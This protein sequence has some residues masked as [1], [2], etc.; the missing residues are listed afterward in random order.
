V[1]TTA[2]TVLVSSAFWCALGFV[3]AGSL[4]ERL[5]GTAEYAPLL[6][7]ALAT[8]LI[9]SV[10]T[11]FLSYL[12]LAEKPRAFV[13]VTVI[14]TLVGTSLTLL[15]LIVLGRGLRGL[16]EAG[17]I[18]QIF[19]LIVALFIVAPEL[20]FGVSFR[21]I[22]ALVRIGF[23]SIFGLFAFFVIDY[24]DRT[25][26]QQ[27]VGLDEVGIYAL[28]YAFGMAIML[29]VDAFSSAWP[30]YFVSYIDRRAEAEVVF[31]QVL[32]YYLI[33]CGA[34]ALCF[35]AFARPVVTLMAAPP[36]HAAYTVVGLVAVAYFIR[37]CYLI[38]LPGIAF[39]KKL[40]F[41]SAVEWFAALLTIALNLMLI[42]VLR[43][44]G[45]ALATSLAYLS[46]PVLTYFLSRRYLKVQHDWHSIAK[47]GG[48]FL[49][50]AV[51]L[52]ALNW[53]DDAVLQVVAAMVVLALYGVYVALVVLTPRERELAI[54]L[55]P[56]LRMVPAWAKGRSTK[57]IH[58]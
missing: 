8:L 16:F 48:G 34:F 27:M 57:G 40:Y 1:W 10:M 39:A 3:L 23:P 25:M 19:V 58:G 9:V 50:T 31:G 47:W 12:R 35:F 15:F 29:A 43:K 24:T 49:T 46:L 13:A 36:Y 42:P 44:E 33:V 18:S 38:L 45:A 7:L 30:A 51:L 37:G 4:S 6:R 17:L 53:V 2:L 11:P 56:T 32:R 55:I 54:E 21:D 28:G 5:L 14:S 41:Q 22:P 20:P 52:T 26:L